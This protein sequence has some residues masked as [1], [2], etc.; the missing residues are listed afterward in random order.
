LEAIAVAL[1]ATA[2]SAPAVIPILLVIIE[3]G[4]L[5]TVGSQLKKKL[6]TKVGKH[7]KIAVLAEDKLSAVNECI[8]KALN[9]KEILEEEYSLVVSELRHKF[10]EMKEKN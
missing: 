6:I 7:E 3:I 2:I 10:R 1:L 8:S 4:S 9:D 5:I